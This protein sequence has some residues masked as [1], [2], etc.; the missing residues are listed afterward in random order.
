MQKLRSDRIGTLT[1]SAGIIT[2]ASTAARPS[3]FTIGGQQYKVTSNLT[4][5]EATHTAVTLYY[6]YAVLSSG[7]VT[8]VR[9]TNVNS[10]GPAGFSA[11]KLV[12][13]Y[14]SDGLGGLGF[15]SFVSITGIPQTLNRIK[16]IGDIVDSGTNGSVRSPTAQTQDYWF[17]RTGKRAI[18]SGGYYHTSNVGSTGAGLYAVKVPAN[19]IISNGNDFSAGS[20][21]ST[22][23]WP[24]SITG[25]TGGAEHCVGM[26]HGVAGGAVNGIQFRM[27]SASD[28]GTWGGGVG[29]IIDAYTLSNGFVGVAWANCGLYV[30]GWSDTPLEDL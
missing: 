7:V 4:Y 28:G 17:E 20:N 9:S 26:I 16:Y 30:T 24:G 11:W 8:L 29:G 23:S 22:S 12:G 15:G 14:Y 25:D 6:I 18:Y 13:A 2:L 5:T 1:E 3:F 27:V 21:S 19:Q 10:V